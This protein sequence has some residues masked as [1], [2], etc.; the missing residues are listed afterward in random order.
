MQVQAGV[1]VASMCCQVRLPGHPT[2][3]GKAAYLSGGQSR[4][5]PQLGWPQA[6]CVSFCAQW[7]YHH[8]PLLHVKC[9]FAHTALLTSQDLQSQSRTKE[10]R[11]PADEQQD[12]SGTSTLGTSVLSPGATIIL[13]AVSSGPAQA[14]VHGLCLPRHSW[15]SG[16]GWLRSEDPCCGSGCCPC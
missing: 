5:R 9:H 1:L 8:C 14:L 6:L 7:P 2:Q 16:A 12:S 3:V 13:S 10:L 11:P 4:E 15:P